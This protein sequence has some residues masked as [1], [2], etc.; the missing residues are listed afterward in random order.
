MS[1]IFESAV[2][3]IFNKFDTS[4]NGILSYPQF[5]ALWTALGRRL[6]PKHFEN[7]LKTFVST[8][9]SKFRASK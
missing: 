3:E 6:E 4:Q 8:K 9:F 5:K 2:E 1:V 7:A